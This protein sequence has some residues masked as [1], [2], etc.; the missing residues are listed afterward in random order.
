[1]RGTFRGVQTGL[2]R[3]SACHFCHRGYKKNALGLILRAKCMSSAYLSLYAQHS[4]V[5]RCRHDWCLS[6]QKKGRFQILFFFSFGV[7]Q[8]EHIC[9]PCKQSDR[10]RTVSE[11]RLERLKFADEST[12]KCVLRDGCFKAFCKLCLHAISPQN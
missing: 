10:L 4:D 1:M 9:K 5:D 3:V 12:G 7:H 6:L 11:G 2:K 8:S